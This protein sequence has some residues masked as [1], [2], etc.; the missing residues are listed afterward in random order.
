MTAPLFEGRADTPHLPTYAFGFGG[1]LSPIRGEDLTGT[2]A[3]AGEA[4]YR[5]ARQER[6]IGPVELRAIGA[7]PL[8]SPMLLM[9]IPCVLSS[10]ALSPFTRK[11][12]SS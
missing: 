8:P 9:K 2:R 12:M 4:M 7:P 6:T 3:F 1:C 11:S 10:R 5:I